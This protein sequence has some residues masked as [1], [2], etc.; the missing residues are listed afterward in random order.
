MATGRFFPYQ[1]DDGALTIEIR[2]VTEEWTRTENLLEPLR[3][4]DRA[5]LPVVDCDLHLAVRCDVARLERLV[6]G[7]GSPV[8]IALRLTGDQSRVRTV[9]DLGPPSKR[10]ERSLPL[11]GAD[12]RGDVS[13]RAH[14]VLRASRPSGS[15]STAAHLGAIIATS[16]PLTVRFDEPPQPLGDTLPVV[17]TSFADR[18]WQS[19]ALFQIEYSEPPAIHLNSDDKQTLRVLDS[20]GTHGKAARVRDAAFTTIAHQGW[21]SLL[22]S[23]LA[24]ARALVEIDHLRPDEVIDNLADWETA[25]LRTWAPRLVPTGGGEPVEELVDGLDAERFAQV[26]TEILPA[27]IQK[28]V[29]TQ[30]F[31][32]S[33][34]I[35][36]R[37]V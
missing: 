32:V 4:A 31:S 11:A 28:E 15:P 25:I 17:W 9:I 16:E 20:R 12:H 8:S 35:E 34:L 1:T 7:D 24:K 18:G 2:D 37:A 19:G 29:Q 33:A 14:A 36:D 13:V 23:V 6:G 10:I 30:H 3:Y 26:L 22:A 5:H 21:T 27:A